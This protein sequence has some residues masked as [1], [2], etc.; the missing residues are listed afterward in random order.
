MQT[1]NT[2]PELAQIAL[3]EN[4]KTALIKHLLIPF[5]NEAEAKTYWE[6]NSVQ[7]II[8]DMPTDAVDEYT[9]PLDD[10]YKISLIIVDN[11]SG[12]YYVT[13]ENTNGN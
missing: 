8:G 6:E 11:D 9:E 13:K 3:P 2:W 10:N 1:I 5:E 7:L 12:R 4:V